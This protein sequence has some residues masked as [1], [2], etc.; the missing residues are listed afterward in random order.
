VQHPER[1]VLANRA[2][3]RDGA[4]EP[5]QPDPPVPTTNERTPRRLSGFPW[6]SSGWNRS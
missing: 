4:E 1:G 5:T 3:G 2:A 6:A